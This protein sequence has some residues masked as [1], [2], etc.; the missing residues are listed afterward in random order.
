[1]EVDVTKSRST[2]V[3]VGR[4]HNNEIDYKAILPEEHPD[5]ICID[6][7]GRLKGEDIWHNMDL[8]LTDIPYLVD[9]LKEYC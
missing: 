8:P 4:D 2:T 3:Y 1:M 7:H 9:L 5:I 6:I